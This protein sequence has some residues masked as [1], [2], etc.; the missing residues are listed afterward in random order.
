M[1]EKTPDPKYA[2][3]NAS[4]KGKARRKR[5]EDAHPERATR[6]SPL[7]AAKARDRNGGVLCRNKF[8]PW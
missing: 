2:R 5:Y 4:A 6:W 3:Y 7:M 1:S 8:H